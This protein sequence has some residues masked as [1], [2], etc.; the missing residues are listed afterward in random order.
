[1]SA[2]QVPASCP[3]CRALFASRALHIG[4]NVKNV[5]LIGNKET[6]PFCGGWAYLADGVFDVADNILSV[7]AAPNV[8]RQ[9]LAAFGAAVKQAYEEKKPP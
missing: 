1:M 2:V 9:M 8:T 4:G 6:C 5:T 7:V 3:S